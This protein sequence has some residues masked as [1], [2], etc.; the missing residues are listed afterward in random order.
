VIAL[1][2]IMGFHLGIAL[3]MGLPWFSLA[4][5]AID[6]VFVTERSWTTAA[7]YTRRLWAKAA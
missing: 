1:I 5:I 3:L 6:F 4:M 2:G 7:A